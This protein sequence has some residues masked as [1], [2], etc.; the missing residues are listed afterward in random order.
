ME[1][2]VQQSALRSI[3]DPLNPGQHKVMLAV[4]DWLAII[5]ISSLIAT[6][7]GHWLAKS[8]DHERWV[9]ENRKQEWRELIDQLHEIL[10]RMHYYHSRLRKDI[11]EDINEGMRVLNSRLFIGDTL[12]KERIDKK[13]GALIGDCFGINESGQVTETEFLTRL[14]TFENELISVAQNDMKPHRARR[15]AF[16]RKG[17]E[18]TVRD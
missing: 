13:W 17:P 10:H 2:E 15:I 12:E 6:A 16:W 9:Y 3:C 5:G 4:K 11:L 8:R 7:L 18:S 1:F 14:T